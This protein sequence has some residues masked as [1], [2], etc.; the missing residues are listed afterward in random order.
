[1]R[2]VC[3]AGASGFIGQKLVERLRA[4]RYTISFIERKDLVAGSV[5]EKIRDCS[6]V[7]N[8]VG[9]SVA[10]LWTKRKKRKIYESRILTTRKL[11]DAINNSDGDIKLLIQVSGIS[12][13]DHIHIHT[14]ESKLF[15]DGFLGHVILDWEKEL[16]GLRRSDL[17]IVILR[18]G[19]VMDKSGGMLKQIILP[20]RLGFGFGIKSDEYFP[21]VHV[22]DL[23]RVFLY[24]FEKQ[25]L[26]GIVNVVAPVPTQIRN[27]FRELG[28]VMNSR[29]KFW[30]GD[31]FIRFFI[32]ELG[33]LV[34]RGQHAV[35]AKLVNEGFKFKYDSIGETFR[36]LMN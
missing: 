6:V 7:V 3:I 29:A 28:E 2:S 23:L 5:G 19:V 30:F 12:V 33:S 21:F 22:E 17:R 31:R 16:A 9:E 20:F 25:N 24:C 15:N 27:F 1:M 36:N 18:L 34:T 8:L 4:E 26:S 32:G 14:E 11:V 13:Y 10:G 35:P